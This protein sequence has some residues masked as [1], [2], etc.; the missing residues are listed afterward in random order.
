MK[1]HLAKLSLA[2]LSTVFL[3]ACQEQ[4]SDPVGPEGLGPEFVKK[5]ET[6]DGEDPHPSCPG[7]GGGEDDTGGTTGVY[8]V[9]FSGDIT[10]TGVDLLQKISDNDIHAASR[11]VN[12][13]FEGILG[14]I[15]NDVQCFGGFTFDVGLGINREKKK[16]RLKAGVV[17]HFRALGTDGATPVGYSLEMG[18]GLIDDP[19]DW[20]PTVI[21]E[22][23][24]NFLAN[25]EDTWTL[26]SGNGGGNEDGACV[27]TGNEDETNLVVTVTRTG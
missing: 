9:L 23:N 12:V 5:G 6:C 17:F 7:G 18:K 13:N 16:P 3:L 20:L 4:G 1:A 24:N 11:F 14:G 8:F 22:D 19:D 10:G 2:L 25:F 15:P 26:T 21:G 27:G